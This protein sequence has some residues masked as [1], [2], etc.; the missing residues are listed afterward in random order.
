MLE[1]LWEDNHLLVV[2]KPAGLPVQ[3]DET[4]DEHLLEIAE[5]YIRE[6]YNKPGAAFVGLIH[7][8]DRPVSGTMMLAKTSKALIRMN[9][10]FR[11][12]QNKKI[13]H[14]IT[15]YALPESEGTLENYLGKDSTTHRA[16]TYNTPRP[17][18]KH[19]VLHYKLLNNRG[20]K[21]LYEIQLETGR[22]HQIRAQ[23][24]KQGSPIMGDLKYGAREPLPDRSIALHAYQLVTPHAVKTNPSLN[25]KAPYP[26]KQ[27][28]QLFADLLK[29]DDFK[30]PAKKK[31]FAKKEFSK[32]PFEKK[33]LTKKP[34]PKKQ[35]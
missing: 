20:D 3:G 32:K 13:Y 24:A 8:I 23:L 9:E 34:G 33:P 4:G 5:R 10:V 15:Q 16:L 17:G 14:C 27:W 21:F 26:N 18:S 30:K 2:N 22:F 1:V 19:A 31:D 7:R 12:K 6:K 25:I 28:W 11:L 29:K 35:P